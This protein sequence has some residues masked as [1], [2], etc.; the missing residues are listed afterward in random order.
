[1]SYDKSKAPWNENKITRWW[2]Y[3]EGT[4]TRVRPQINGH[5]LAADSW[6]CSTIGLSCNTLVTL[7][8]LST[9]RIGDVNSTV[10]KVWCGQ[11]T[12]QI[13]PFAE[14]A[15]L[16]RDECHCISKQTMHPRPF[17]RRSL[18]PN[19][20]TLV[21]NF[22]PHFCNLAPFRYWS[23]TSSPAVWYFNRS[24]SYASCVTLL[25]RH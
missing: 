7:I 21:P 13:K 1:M 14:T 15:M 19:L 10:G 25:H 4:L 5:T 2:C 9:Y 12:R 16:P 22:G 11:C 17:V 24:I 8:S 18:M 20:L 6:T 3:R 23:A